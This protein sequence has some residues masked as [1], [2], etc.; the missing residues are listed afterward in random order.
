M[1]EAARNW[2][3]DIKDLGD[4]NVN[5]TL[6]QAKELGDYHKEEHGLETR[7]VNMHTVKPLDVT[8]L[9]AADDETGLVVTAEEHQVGGF[10]GIIAAA[11]LRQRKSPERPLLFDMV[12]VADRFGLSGKPWDLM[13]EFGLC[14]E[15]IAERVLRLQ[16]R[17][18]EKPKIAPAA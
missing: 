1:A 8:A 15:H 4:K 13:R 11:I 10:G 2:S 5:L 16:T 12:G 18:E 6:L 17:R 7:I 14:A 3:S 9:A